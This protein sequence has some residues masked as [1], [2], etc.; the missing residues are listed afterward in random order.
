[1]IP[2]CA[3][4]SYSTQQ[5]YWPIRAGFDQSSTADPI[6]IGYLPSSFDS[7]AVLVGSPIVA[8]II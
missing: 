8:E 7:T 2:G 3:S 1:M 4:P 6:F 5:L